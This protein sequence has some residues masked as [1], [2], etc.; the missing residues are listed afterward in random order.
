MGSKATCWWGRG[1]PNDDSFPYGEVRKVSLQNN[2]FAVCGN[3]S[4]SH[5]KGQIKIRVGTAP[6]VWQLIGSHTLL[7]LRICWKK[8]GLFSPQTGRYFNSIGLCRLLCVS[9]SKVLFF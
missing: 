1:S 5:P 7:Y 9:I 4:Y 3:H 6:S 8:V 2:L